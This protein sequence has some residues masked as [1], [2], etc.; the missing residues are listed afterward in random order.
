MG[1]IYGICRCRLQIVSLFRDSRRS[2]ACTALTKSE[3]KERLLAVQCRCE[4]YGFQAVYS[5]VGYI[6]QRVW[7]Q[8]RVSFSRKLIS[9]LKILVQTR[10]TGNCRSKYKEIKSV[11]FWLDYASDLGSFWKTATLGQGWGRGRNWEF[12]LVQGSKILL[13]QLRYKLRIPGSQPDISTQKFLK[14]PPEFP[15]DFAF[16]AKSLR[17]QIL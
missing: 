8:N 11:L 17:G 3:E 4:G 13:S 7:V 12:S 9:W 6:N 15:R 1:Y 10:E 16:W 2:R 14:Q 5:G